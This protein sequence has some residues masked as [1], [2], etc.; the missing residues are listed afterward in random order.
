MTASSP[1]QALHTWLGAVYP[2][3]PGRSAQALSDRTGSVCELPPLGLSSGALQ[4]LNLGFETCPEQTQAL[5]CLLCVIVMLKGDSSPL[6][7]VVYTLP[8]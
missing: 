5:S 4:G 3:L 6:S 1:L 8:F 7:Q 2:I